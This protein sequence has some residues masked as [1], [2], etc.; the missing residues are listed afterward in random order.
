MVLLLTHPTITIYGNSN[1]TPNPSTTSMTTTTTWKVIPSWPA[2][3]ASTDGQIRRHR[4]GKILSP[5]TQKG[6][7]PYQRVNLYRG[8]KAVRNRVHRLILETF[9][10][11]CP[12]GH[13]TLH[14]DDDPRNN[15]LGNLRWGTRE[16]NH[17]TIRWRQGEAHYRAELTEDDV[18][19]IRASTEPHVVLARRLGVS[20]TTIRDIRNHK[21]W[22]HL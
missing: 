19:A 10:G 1:N 6:R 3:E 7:Q 22:K 4:T 12:E 14:L 21:T 11:P 17:S 15:R 9:V 5:V 18:R 8:G 13:E 20:E 2:Y 16:E